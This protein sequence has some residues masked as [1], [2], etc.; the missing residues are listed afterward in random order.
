MSEQLDLPTNIILATARH[1][2]SSGAH[3]SEIFSNEL[4]S[5]IE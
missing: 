5:A 3:V 2:L 1:R 4:L